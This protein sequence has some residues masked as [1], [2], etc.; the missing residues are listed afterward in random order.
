MSI[1]PKRIMYLD[2][3]RSLAIMLVVIGHVSRLFSYDFYSWLFC[4]GVF[5]LTR[6]GVPLFFTVSADMALH[7]YT[8]LLYGYCLW[9]TGL[10]K[11]FLVYLVI[12]WSLS[13]YSSCRQLHSWRGNEGSGISDS[14]YIHTFNS[15]YNRLFRLSSNE[16]Q[17]QSD[18]QLLPG[19]RILHHGILHSQ[20]TVQ[21]F[22]QKDVC[23]RM[24]SI[25]YRNS[26]T[27]YKNL[28]KGTWRICLGSNRLLWHLC[29]LGNHGK[30][31]KRL[32]YSPHAVLESTSHIISYSIT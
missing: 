3:V 28:P 23:N 25:P 20:Q 18:I 10:F 9:C 16:I 12:D 19:S 11:T 22:R 29:N 32:S 31:E 21:I 1:S 5:S 4:S 24:W 15:L 17:L 14:H 2:E 7:P 6:I 26:G 13:A 30:S 27:L 8:Y